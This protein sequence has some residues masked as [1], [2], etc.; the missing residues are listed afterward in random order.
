MTLDNS[1]LMKDFRIDTLPEIDPDTLALHNKPED[2]WISVHGFVIDVTNFKHQ[3]G[4]VVLQRT[5][6][7]DITQFFTRYH[8]GL[9]AIYLPNVILKGRVK[10]AKHLSEL[11]HPCMLTPIQ[12]I[13]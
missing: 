2:L 13:T 11:L 12:Q 3:G 7:K 1:K 6:G 8:R 4:Q 9:N 10:G 5:A